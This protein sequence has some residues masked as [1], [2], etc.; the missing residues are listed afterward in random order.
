MLIAYAAAEEKKYMQR[1]PPGSPV[2]CPRSPADGFPAVLVSAALFLACATSGRAAVTDT[3]EPGAEH[4]VK[5]PSAGRALER[6]LLLH[7]IGLATDYL[8]KSVHEEKGGAARLYDARND[9]P[10]GKLHTTFTSSVVYSL[11]KA[12][13]LLQDERISPRMD[14]ATKF[15]LSMQNTDK[16]S[17]RHGAF[18]YS[19]DLLR[20]EKQ[21]RYAVGTAAKC[22]FALLQLHGARGDA[23]YLDSARAAGDWLMTMIRSNGSMRP[24][25]RLKKGR[26]VCARKESLLYS[27]QV[28]SA[29]SRLCAATRDDRYLSTA[30]D[31]AHRLVAKAV[32][33]GYYP[34]DDYRRKNAIS[35]SWV[36]MSL[37][38]FYKVS[39]DTY[40]RDVLLACGREV[41]KRQKLDPEDTVNYGR[42]S[43]TQYT[44]GNGWISEVMI[45]IYGLCKEEGIPD[46]EQY[47]QATVRVSR[48]LDRHTYTEDNTSHLKNPDRAL[49]GLTR[50]PHDP[51]VR[52]DAVCHAL[53]AYIALLDYLE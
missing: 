8:L 37:L 28:L 46:A 27:G 3:I 47:L 25:A 12:D 36:A 52:V 30:R 4:P 32:S 44:S 19:Y 9:D 6:K 7:N 41:L 39:G 5:A 26:W 34:G 53:N 43:G 11:L 51:S 42:W 18:H 20:D 24:Y 22:I 17:P 23:V 21:Q 45:E 15:L 50:S 31:I 16:E 33:E 1:Y 2:A 49:G 10:G 29:L 13:A 35:T 40:Y 48:W 14:S 38:D